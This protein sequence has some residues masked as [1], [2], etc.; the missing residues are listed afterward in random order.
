MPGIPTA[1]VFWKKNTMYI[2][3]GGLYDTDSMAWVNDATV[4]VTLYD[5]ASNVVAGVS[6]VMCMY[7]PNSNG[8][9][10]GSI[11]YS[12]NP[13]EG[14]DYEMNIQVDAGGSRNNHRLPAVV[15]R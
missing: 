8:N 3:L 14:D 6:G 12:F 4:Q 9:Y 10:K 5:S 13:L 1:V 2:D 7:V 15:R 11:P